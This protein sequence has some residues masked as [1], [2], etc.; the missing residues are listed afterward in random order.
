LHGTGEI[1]LESA[2]RAAGYW[3]TRSDSHPDVNERTSGFYLRAD[4]EDI[5]IMDGRDDRQRAALIE[6]RLTHWKSTK[7]A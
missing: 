6:E 7:T 3:T 5:G 1:R 2:D 4:P